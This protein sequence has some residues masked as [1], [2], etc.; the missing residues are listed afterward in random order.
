MI[1]FLLNEFMVVHQT[2]APYHPQANGQAE[3]TNKTLCTALT[4]IVEGNRTDWE[5]KLPS[6]LWAYRCAYKI[7]L[8]TTPFNLV[9]GLDAILPI[10]FLVPTLRV[11]HLLE[12]N[13][14]ELSNW[15]NE[16][17]LLDETRMRAVM[18]VYTEKRRQK[19]WHDTNLRTKESHKGTLVLVYTLK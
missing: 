15:V 17:E 12:W 13:G 16:L 19:H 6:V 10:E 2:S 11:A 3:S 1:E 8:N 18:G 5:Q 4:K 14:H 7:A 9:Y